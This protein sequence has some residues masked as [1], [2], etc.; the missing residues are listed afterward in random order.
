[1]HVKKVARGPFFEGKSASTVVCASK[2]ERNENEETSCALHARSRSHIVKSYRQF[3]VARGTPALQINPKR[4]NFF[5]VHPNVARPPGRIARRANQN[6]EL[7]ADYNSRR[8]KQEF[9]TTGLAIKYDG[10][11]GSNNLGAYHSYD[12]V[13]NR[14]AKGFDLLDFEAE[15]AKG[16]PFQDIYFFRKRNI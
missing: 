7:S 10:P 9:L 16:N 8:A 15:G 3:A 6:R 5:D 1:M 12:Y 4:C 14:L 13:S 11:V 2:S